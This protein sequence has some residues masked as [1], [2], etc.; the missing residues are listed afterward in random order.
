MSHRVNRVQRAQ[1][2]LYDAVLELVSAVANS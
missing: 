1:A 2:G